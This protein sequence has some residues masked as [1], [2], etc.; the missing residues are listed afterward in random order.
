MREQEDLNTQKRKASSGRTLVKR[1]RA[2]CRDRTPQKAGD[3]GL[4]SARKLSTHCL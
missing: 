3:M 4:L 2:H 1:N